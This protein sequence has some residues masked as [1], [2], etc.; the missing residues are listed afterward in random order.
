MKLKKKDDQSVDISVLLR[1]GN[2]IPMGGVTKMKCVTEG[3]K[4]HPETALPGDPSHVQS[5]NQHYCG[6]QQVLADTS[7]IQLSPQR[8][9]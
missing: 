9:C 6:C 1:R 2:N 5:P 3:R 4:G 7:L 8:F